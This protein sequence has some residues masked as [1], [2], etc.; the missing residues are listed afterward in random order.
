V[1]SLGATRRF[2]D[3]RDPVRIGVELGADV[4]VDGTLQLA[5]ERLRLTARLLSAGDGVQRWNERYDVSFADVM[6]LQ[7]SLC[8]RVAE[9]LRLEVSVAAWNQHLPKEAAELYLR[10]RHL[11][12]RQ[13]LMRRSEVVQMLR[14]CLELAPG[15]SPAL[16]M[17]AM[18]A[19]RAVWIEQV[20]HQ[21][22][23][24][25]EAE[26]ALA[27]AERNAGELAE[28]HLARG[29]FMTQQGRYRE[30]VVALLRAV[31]IA[32]TLPDA[33]QYLGGLQ[34]EAGRAREGIARLETSL[35]L[36][37]QLNLSRLA[38][39]RVHALLGDDET[40]ERHLTIIHGSVEEGAPP[41]LTL[42]V[43][44]AM[45][46]RDDD[47]AR[48]A[49]DRLLRIADDGGPI[50]TFITPLLLYASGDDSRLPDVH[51]FMTTVRQSF[52]NR[53]FHSMMGQL[54]LEVLAYRGRYDDALGLL[55]E[56]S[57][58]VLADLVWLEQCAL[59]DPLRQH[60]RFAEAAAKVRHRVTAMWLDPD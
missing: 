22:T 15:F 55:S 43:R 12:R 46:R 17:L 60:P 16:A 49:I 32:P 25:Q 14:R 31:E 18:A 9:A 56:L 1:F 58:G 19:V 26:L 10:A 47:G 33:Q 13:L 36:D 21:G 6:A 20:A 48:R 34:C 44:L 28:T 24:T 11:H 39:A 2:A 4:V 45:Y 8:R 41:V 3:E 29:N 50:R 42:Y 38:L 51:S 53:R 54:A 37:P 5:G 35:E 30:A 27:A 59:F 23:L 40:A 7:E 57:D 52:A